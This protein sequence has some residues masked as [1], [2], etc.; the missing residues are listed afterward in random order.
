MTFRKSGVKKPEPLTNSGNSCFINSIEQCFRALES[1]F[2]V[3]WNRTIPNDRFRDH[4]QHD[5]HEYLMFILDHIEKRVSKD[6]FQSYFQGEYTTRV[7]FP[8]GHT[9]RHHEPFCVLSVACV[10]TM[11]EMI[12]SLESN[13]DVTSECDHCQFKGSAKKK[14]HVS[15]LPNVVTFHIK[16]FN[17]RFEKKNQK[18]DLPL[19]W[20]FLRKD[21]QF[22]CTGFIIHYGSLLGGHYIAVCRIGEKW[23][24]CN[25]QHIAEIKQPVEQLLPHAYLVFYTRS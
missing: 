25:D 14:T 9:N 15:S 16:R 4:R 5:A 12:S 10:P 23:W 8:C 11:E 24:M 22:V 19:S 17:H 18:V 21:R 1:H 20:T 3:T 2:H 13:D 6:A 7:S